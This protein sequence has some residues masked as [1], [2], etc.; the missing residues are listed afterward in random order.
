M[1]CQHCN[2]W[3]QSFRRMDSLDVQVLVEIVEVLVLEVLGARSAAAASVASLEAPALEVSVAFEDAEAFEAFVA[4]VAA[5][6]SERRRGTGWHPQSTRHQ[7]WAP[8][9]DLMSP[10]PFLQHQ[11]MVLEVNMVQRLKRV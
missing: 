6:G 8:R 5:L 4:A 9:Q 10:R 7:V 11:R 3:P 2:G 1:E